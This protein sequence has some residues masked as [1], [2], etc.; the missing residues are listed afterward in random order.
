MIW[1]TVWPG[2][3]QP[4][5]FLHMLK[6]PWY[7]LLYLPLLIVLGFMTWRQ[8]KLKRLQN[9]LVTPLRGQRYWRVN[10]AQP[11]FYERRLRLMPYEAKGVLID[12]G[13]QLRIRGFRLPGL[14]FFDSVVDK[15]QCTVEWLGTG[16][17]WMSSSACWAKLQ[18]AR[19]TMYFSPDTAQPARDSREALGDIFRSLFPDYPLDEQ[20][21]QDFALE[22]NP[23]S[24]TAI[25][26]FFALFLFSLI[27][28]FAISRFELTDAQLGQ[29]LS[30]PLTLISALAAGALLT[31]ALYT[32]LRQG[33]VPSQESVALA[34]MVSCAALG[35]ALPI[36]KRVDQ[37]LAPQAAQMY[38]YRVEQGTRL[39]PINT[40]LGLP[41][42]RFPRA[43]DYWKQVPLGSEYPIPLLRG[44]LGLWQ[45]D[46]A[47]FD[48]PLRDFYGKQ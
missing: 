42:L 22:K 26:A 44:P 25:V 10:L 21:T 1:R 34:L 38:A 9:E 15:N 17:A 48:K 36:A 47:E 7:L 19:G 45:L 31:W 20:Q 11:Q 2:T 46:H 13:E 33:H 8:R 43:A 14:R 6:L 23:R 37:G 16:N 41:A 28:S 5:D 18:T 27:D 4:G 35:A 12:E 29:L 39:Q 32:V 40:S 24:V 30:H 3:V